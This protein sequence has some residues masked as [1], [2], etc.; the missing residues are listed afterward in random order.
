ME[1]KNSSKVTKQ[2]ECVKIRSDGTIKF[3]YNI[4]PLPCMSEFLDDDTIIPLQ[5]DVDEVHITENIDRIVEEFMEEL[6]NETWEED[7]AKEKDN[8]G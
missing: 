1:T 6:E 3:L 4:D 2:E 8:C 7:S 5:F